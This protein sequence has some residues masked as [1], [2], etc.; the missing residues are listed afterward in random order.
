[1]ALKILAMC[2]SG[3]LHALVQALARSA[4]QP[5]VGAISDV[6]NPRLVAK[7]LFYHGRTDDPEFVRNCVRE[8]RPDLVVIGPEEP[9]LAGIADML[10][11]EGIPCVGPLQKLA[12]LETSKAF[13][14]ELMTEYGIQGCPEHRVFM[15]MNGIEDYLRALSDFVIKPDGLTGGKGVKVSGDHI[16]SL[17]EGLEYCS[18][19]FESGQQK[20]VIEEKLDGE[21]FSFQSFFD[22]RHIAHMVP[23]QDHKR[24]WDGDRGPNTGGMGSYSCADHKLPFLTNENLQAAR[25]INQ[26]IGEAL[27]KKTGLQY[28]GILYGGFML[29]KHGLK[30]I[31]YNARFGDPEIMN[32]LPILETDFVD[33]CEAIVSGTLDKLAIRFSKRATVCK[34]IV[35]KEYPSK[36]SAKELIDVSALDRMAAQEPN[37]YVYYGAVEGARD[38]LRMTGSR[39]IGVVGTGETLQDAEEIAERAASLV[40]GPVYH[41][42]DIGTSELIEKRKKHMQ[43]VRRQSSQGLSKL[44]S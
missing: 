3:R 36:A 24:A 34:Y 20:V 10:A 23:V 29:T 22:G 4:R 26:A 41:R 32:V 43:N 35:P 15:S 9:L 28:K 39:A 16:G 18:E 13:T 19:L 11:A 42:R 44:A 5:I 38:E 27:Y 17:A 31:E 12:Q 25:E 8:F 37:L 30:V 21:E 14:R 40:K 7:E 33:V 2:K 1:M 6:N